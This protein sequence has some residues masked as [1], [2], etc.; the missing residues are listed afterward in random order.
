MI[1]HTKNKHLFYLIKENDQRNDQWSQSMSQSKNQQTQ[2]SQNHVH[3]KHV[4]EQTSALED[5]TFLSHIISLKETAMLELGLVD[6]EP[7]PINL[8]MASHIIDTLEVLKIKTKGNLTQDE[9]L[10]LDR[11]I[12]DLKIQF[13]KTKK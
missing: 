4:N 3:H 1:D 11:S 13:L 6:G 5:L 9:T 7:Q 12:A 8:E 10:F 2:N